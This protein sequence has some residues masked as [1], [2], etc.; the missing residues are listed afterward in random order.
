VKVKNDKKSKEENRRDD[1][2]E[3]NKMKL[4]KRGLFG[5]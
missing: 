1:M 2:K 4:F 3:G 5:R